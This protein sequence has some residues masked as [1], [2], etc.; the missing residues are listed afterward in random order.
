MAYLLNARGIL[1]TLNQHLSPNQDS[2]TVGRL[3][4]TPLEN[5]LGYLAKGSQMGESIDGMAVIWRFYAGDQCDLQVEGGCRRFCGEAGLRIL[6]PRANGEEEVTKGICQQLF[7]HEQ[8][9]KA[10]PDEVDTWIF[11]TPGQ[12]RKYILIVT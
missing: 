5:G 3:A 6:R 7:V 2:Y 1:L 8:K 4:P 10:Y 11:S 12:G 9:A